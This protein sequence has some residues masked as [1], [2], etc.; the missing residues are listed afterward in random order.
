MK[1]CVCLAIEFVVRR[2]NFRWWS[3]FNY[4]LS[5]ALDSGEDHF[6]LNRLSWV[7]TV[8]SML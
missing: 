8:M 5:A 3:K 1:G 2:R 4:I 6:I 7:L